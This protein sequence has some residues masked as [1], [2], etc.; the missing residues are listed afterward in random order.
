[1]KYRIEPIEETERF[2][3]YKLTLT[4]ESREEQTALH[5]NAIIAMAEAGEFIGDVY[6]A[7][8]GETSAKSGTVRLK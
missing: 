2:K 5:D 8:H 4:I 6:R 1:M 7:G 3:P